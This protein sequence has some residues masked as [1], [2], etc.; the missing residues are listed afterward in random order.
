MERV[1]KVEE[2]TT[3]APQNKQRR[4]T[5]AMNKKKNSETNTISSWSTLNQKHENSSMNKGDGDI[6]SSNNSNK[7]RISD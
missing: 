2:K 4:I 1:W 5:G 7:H 3:G 6:D